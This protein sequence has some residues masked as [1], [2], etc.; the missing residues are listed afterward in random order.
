MCLMWL[1]SHLVFS[2]V[3][4]SQQFSRANQFYRDGKF[5]EA[6]Q[7][8]EEIVKSKPT[9]E[10]YYNLGNAYFKT[11]KIGFAILN[12]ERAR[13]LKP[14]DSDVL[15]N[16]AYANRL[17]EYKIEDKRNWYFKKKSELL[18]FLTLLECWGIA[19]SAYFVFILGFLVS[20]LMR[21]E[22]LFG[23]AGALGLA[24]VI[25]CSF[26]L[27]LKYGEIGI[28]ERGIVTENQIEVRYGP[29]KSDRI[30]FR[31]VEGLEL[32]IKDKKDDWYRIELRDGRSGWTSASQV[33]MI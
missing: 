29:T 32:F 15:A 8:Y 20:L 3:D 26:P 19:L 21:K 30:A 14:R 24:L 22:P 33:E 31:L 17:I 9:A 6:V 18:S 2:A 11:K 4:V 16:L 23:R 7:G 5:D 1:S 28:G 27:L 10:V 25:F 13:S 12:Y